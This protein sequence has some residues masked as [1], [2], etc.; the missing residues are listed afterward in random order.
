MKD[1]SLAAHYWREID[2]LCHLEHCS[3]ASKIDTITQLVFT[4]ITKLDSS[5]SV[6]EQTSLEKLRAQQALT[7]LLT[8]DEQQRLLVLQLKAGPVLSPSDKAHLLMELCRTQHFANKKIVARV[9]TQTL[10]ALNQA[11][12]HDDAMAATIMTLF[13]IKHA[14]LS[15]NVGQLLA[16]HA[17]QALMTLYQKML[18]TLRLKKKAIGSL[19]GGVDDYFC[20]LGHFIARYQSPWADY[21]A[22]ERYIDQLTA[23]YHEG[24][25]SE[26]VALLSQQ[27]FK[28]N[29]VGHEIALHQNPRSIRHYFG[30]LDL[31]IQDKNTTAAIDLLAQTNHDGWHQGHIIARHQDVNVMRDYLDSITLLLENS[32]ERESEAIFALLRQTT[33]KQ[34]NLGYFIAVC[35]FDRGIDYYLTFLKTLVADGKKTQVFDLLAQQ[36]RHGC[37]FSHYLAKQKNPVLMSA[38]CELLTSLEPSHA[39][40]LLTQRNNGVIL[41]T[42][43]NKTQ[44]TTGLNFGHAI[45]RSTEQ[46][47]RPSI[48]AYLNLLTHLLEKGEFRDVLN[49]LRQSE[50]K[51]WHLKYLIKHYHD[52][53]LLS[54]YQA[55]YAKA[56]VKVLASEGY[57]SI[58]TDTT[59]FIKYKDQVKNYLNGLKEGK[60]T[61]ALL[62]KCLD[63]NAPLGIYCHTLRGVGAYFC[64]DNDENHTIQLI[65]HKLH[66][67]LNN[68]RRAW[69]TRTPRSE[70]RE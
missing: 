63:K 24:Q 65:K 17:D 6:D 46:R 10:Q 5:L 47:E 25:T 50:T 26:V 53:A 55:L 43:S 1:H 14:L 48:E 13:A 49:L 40:A 62:Q 38:Y 21:N 19:L 7:P 29:S 27:N 61:R 28:G 57:T 45:A 31:F 33:L 67:P 68:V 64:P 15:Q 51:G 42:R 12:S 8:D 2:R 41:H 22:T 52:Q 56:I 39:T 69:F 23:L 32:S 70:S 34:E 36:D 3:D 11:L 18:V 44:R 59:L 37:N 9:L 30:L 66:I 54:Q 60:T 20:A 16:R 4:A 35:H 58:Q